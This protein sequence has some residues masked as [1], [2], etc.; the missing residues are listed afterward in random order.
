MSRFRNKLKEELEET[1]KARQRDIELLKEKEEKEKAKLAANKHDSNVAEMQIHYQ[2]EKMEEVKLRLEE[3]LEKTRAR[4]MEHLHQVERARQRHGERLQEAQKELE[5]RLKLKFL[6]HPSNPSA[7]DLKKK[8]AIQQSTSLVIGKKTKD[9]PK[10]TSEDTMF[11]SS[12]KMRTYQE[13]M[14][15]VSKNLTHIKE[16]KEYELVRCNPVQNYSI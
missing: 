12:M 10:G 3:N 2:E 6:K 15:E 4:A 11:V 7:T 1:K 5:S 9:S 16:E 8:A 14:K 13:R